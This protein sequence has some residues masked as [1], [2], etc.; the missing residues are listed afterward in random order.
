MTSIHIK[1]LPINDNSNGWSKLLD[2]RT[3]RPAL[4]GSHQAH[5]V[6]VG[7]GYA[8][9]AAA[10]RLAELR[11]DDRI[12]LIEAGVGIAVTG[13]LLSIFHAFAAREASAAG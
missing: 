11:P 3:P 1:H 7:A 9:L 12:I 6:V 8:G 2:G 4:Q 13:V 5:S 10:R